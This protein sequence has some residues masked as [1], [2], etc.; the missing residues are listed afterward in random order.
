MFTILNTMKKYLPG[1]VGV[2]LGFL[3]S[4]AIRNAISAA[5]QCE[6]LSRGAQ[7]ELPS[8]RIMTCQ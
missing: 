7:I 5:N 8:G 4:G 3:V 6:N 2:I 1:A